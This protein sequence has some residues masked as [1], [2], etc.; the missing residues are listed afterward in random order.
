MF[1]ANH[2]KTLCTLLLHWRAL[3][4]LV[5]C[6]MLLATA[7]TFISQG[8]DARP[9]SSF[10]GEL[11]LLPYSDRNISI[12]F[13]YCPNSDNNRPGELPDFLYTLLSIHDVQLLPIVKPTGKSPL[14]LLN[15]YSGSNTPR[16]PPIFS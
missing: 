3:A 11:V 12:R 16:A 8:T 10:S 9:T 2:K 14:A 4:L 5:V 1:Q 6:F 7:K 15:Y 13:E